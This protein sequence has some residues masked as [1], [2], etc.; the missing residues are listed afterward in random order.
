MR[1]GRVVWTWVMLV[2]CFGLV[3]AA[4]SGWESTGVLVL[5]ISHSMQDNDPHNIRGDGE[6]T[7]IDLLSAV[8][9]NQLGI[10][11]FGAKARVMKP[12]TAIQRETVKSLKASLPP[13]DSRAQ[14]TEIGLGVARGME[15]LGERGGTRYLVVMSDGD[16][17]RSGRAAKRWTRDDELALREL[18]ALY[19]KLRQENI[20]IFTI[21]LTESSRKTLAGGAEPHPGEPVQMTSGEMLLQE[22]A[23]STQGKFFR[24]LRQRDYL[25]AFLDIFL[26]LRPPTIFTLPRQP[27]AKFYLSRFDSEAIVIGPRDM[28][29]MTPD[30]QRIG[31]GVSLP[32]GTPWVRVFPYQHWSLAVIARPLDEV[33]NYEGT[34]Q[35]VDQAGNP[36][37]D[38]KVL[39][40]SALAL[41][42]DRQPKPEYALYE[43]VPV[44][45]KVHSF[46]PRSLAEDQQLAEYLQKAE[47]VASV[48]APNSPLPL[49]QRLTPQGDDGP[50]VFS[51][52]FAELT[53]EG[54]YRLAVEL[55]NEP[56][57]SLNRKMEAVFS[58]GPPYFHFGITRLGSDP[59]VRVLGSGKG[60]SQPPVFAEDRL[61]LVAELSGR[62]PVDFQHE[63]TLHGEIVR[64]G[65][66][67]QVLPLERM[68]EGETVRYRSKPFSLSVPGTY[69]VVFRAEG[70]T[71]AEVWDERVIS[72]RSLRT[73]PMQI[74]FPGELTVSPIPWTPGRL[75]KYLAAG[76]LAMASTIAAGMAL[77][78]NF[79]R[80]PLHGW[81]LSTGPGTPQ[82]LVLS[83]NPHAHRWRRIFPKKRATV[84]T[85]PHCDHQL[86]LR[87]TGVEVEAEISVGPWWDRSGS[88]YLRSTRNPSHVS[89]D[90]VE[91]TAKEAVVLMDG[92]ALEKPARIQFGH[93]E[94]TFDA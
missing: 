61:E 27:D 65:Q 3:T 28:V 6:Q 31:L 53:T 72:T 35:V 66:A 36:L 23:E 69:G 88:L 89:I 18:R 8:D 47:V 85:G 7:F 67:L 77:L 82:L 38:N 81:L 44:A 15:L 71:T 17:D 55:L 92:M 43:T 93:C 76:V 12:I 13:I 57:P 86:D 58:V 41:A 68:Q 5:D 14:R 49:S 11:F 78:G 80:T 33:G 56:R 2:A 52:T 45:I 20:P 94:M 84:G 4:E 10:I 34:Y 70:H 39:V 64:A 87:D 73:S 42:W 30:A 50:F 19:P 1:R 79:V 40:N 24:I 59:P 21:A 75:G 60:M 22:M 48:W 74:V 9:G 29:L 62:M 83:G 37:H 16:L 46:G 90:G 32:A 54:T 91:V 63:P 26:H 25:D 51:G